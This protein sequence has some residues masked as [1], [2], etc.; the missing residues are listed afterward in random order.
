MVEHEE[1]LAP[2]PTDPLREILKDLG[3]IP[4]VEALL[5]NVIVQSTISS[6]LLRWST[7]GC[8]WRRQGR[9]NQWSIQARTV[10]DSNKQI[11]SSR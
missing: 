7:R 10:S 8:P 1:A 3:A 5:G 11:W 9:C 4:S 6:C 2:E